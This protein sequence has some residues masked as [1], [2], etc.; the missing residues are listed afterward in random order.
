MYIFLTCFFYSLV[1]SI[2]IVYYIVYYFRRKM[3]FATFS[4]SGS[5]LNGKQI[6][7]YFYKRFLMFLF[8]EINPDGLIVP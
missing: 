7:K 3:F 2:V 4:F 6:I 5:N 1:G 8:L